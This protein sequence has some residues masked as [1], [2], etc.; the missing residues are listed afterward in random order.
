MEFSRDAEPSSVDRQM[1]R[2]SMHDPRSF[3]VCW[4]KHKDN[5]K[6]E[7]RERGKKKWVNSN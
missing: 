7:E 4:I 1:P 2:S 5:D 6:D 3:P